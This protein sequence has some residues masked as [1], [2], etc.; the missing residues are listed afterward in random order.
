MRQAFGVFKRRLDDSQNARLPCYRTA[1]WNH[2][3]REGRIAL[4]AR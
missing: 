4:F 1:P 3:D 2:A